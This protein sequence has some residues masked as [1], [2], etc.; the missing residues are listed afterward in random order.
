MGSSLHAFTRTKRENPDS[1]FF[2]YLGSDAD[3][4]IIS[5]WKTLGQGIPGGS[6]LTSANFLPT[7]LSDSDGHPIGIKYSSTLAYEIHVF[8]GT[9]R[10]AENS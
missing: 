10:N 8:S 6:P 7:S 9:L 4:I 5:F 2:Q 3:L 1:K